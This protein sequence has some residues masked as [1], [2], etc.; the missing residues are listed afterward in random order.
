MKHSMMT[1][2]KEIII[3]MIIMFISGLLSS[4][5]IWVV[6]LSDIRI[7][8][9]DIYMALLMCG[10]SLIFMGLYYINLSILLIGIIIT[11]LIV[12]CIRT[13]LFIDETQYIKGMIPHHS[14]AILMSNKLLQKMYNN[15]INITP[16][17]KKLAN[18]IIINQENEI[19]FMKVQ[20]KVK[21]N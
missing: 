15:T 2:P 21:N 6:K 18:S 12:Y 3:M 16:G 1:E 17:I 14:M 4:M 13:Q 5:N 19:N 7:H 9:N 20:S 10:W 8:L 11:S